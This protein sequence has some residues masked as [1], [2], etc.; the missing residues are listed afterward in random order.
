M[1]RERRL[2]LVAIT[3][4]AVIAF[5]RWGLVGRNPQAPLPS[6]LEGKTVPEAVE[7]PLIGSESEVLFPFL[8]EGEEGWPAVTVVNFWGSWCTACEREMPHLVAIDKEWKA[9][10]EEG[11]ESCPVLL[12]VAFYDAL[13]NA[14]AFLE[15]HDATYPNYLDLEGKVVVGWGIYGAPETFFVDRHGKIVERWVGPIDVETL[16]RIAGEV[17]ILP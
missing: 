13:E 3:V 17:A 7:L 4:A 6:A 8:A 12:G 10:R 1:T 14:T 9:C 16:R 2:A 15:N 5:L 11:G